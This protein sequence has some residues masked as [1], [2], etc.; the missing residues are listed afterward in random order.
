MRRFREQ[1]AT[2]AVLGVVVDGADDEPVELEEEER[3]V[4]LDP[5]LRALG[6]QKRLGL[7][8]LWRR[9]GICQGK[10]LDAAG[11]EGKGRIRLSALPGDRLFK[12]SATHQSTLLA[13]IISITSN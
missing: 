1:K 2:H 5:L 8:S 13:A 7:R 9:K 10:E 6:A 11:D 4:L 12:H 3:L